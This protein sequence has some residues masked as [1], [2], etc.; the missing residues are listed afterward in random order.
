M[1]EVQLSKG[2]VALIDDEDLERVL[3]FKW[4]AHVDS[5]NEKV[6]AA[7]SYYRKKGKEKQPSSMHRF[8]LGE[9]NPKILIDHEDGDGLNN[10]K[11]NLRRSTPQLNQANKNIQR[12]NISGYKG[13]TWDKVAKKWTASIGVDM[14]KLWIG[15]FSDKE[16]AAKAYDKAAIKHFGIFAV[17][18]FKEEVTNE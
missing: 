7:R 3:K 4:H 9:L 2:H 6:Y 17:L 14:K 16:I 5:K 10:Q 13:V 18:N 11:H 15:R 8:L 12:D 1:K